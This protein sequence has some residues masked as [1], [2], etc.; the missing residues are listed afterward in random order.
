VGGSLAD[1]FDRRRLL[2][3]TQ[4]SLTAT[5]AGLMVNALSDRPAL[6]PIYLCTTAAAGLSGV[7]APT[8]AAA[9]PTLVGRR[10]VPSAAALNQTLIQLGAVAGPALAGLVIARFSLGAAYAID[11]V[12]FG[13][14]IAAL[15]LMEP[16]IPLGGGTKAGFGSIAEGL[17]YL[18][19]QRA[20]Q[21]TFLVDIVAMV[22]GMPRALFPQI[23]T[24]L[25]GGGAGTVGL[26]Y[27][28]PGVGAFAGAVTTGWVSGVL[29]PGRAVLIAVAVWGL[30]IAGFGMATWLPV[31]LLL[32]VVAGWADVL[33]AVFRGTILQLQVPDRLRGRL[34]AINI[35]VVTGGPRLGDAE[36]GAVAALT[37]AQASVVSGGLACLAGVAVLARVR[38]ELA[39]WRP[40]PHDPDEMSGDV[41]DADGARSSQ[42]Q[43]DP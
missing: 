13:A 25:Y 27:A 40:P 43:G 1:A 31:G 20:V 15:L 33:S 37:S 39:A 9:I 42:S 21:G 11:V 5:S 30:A 18:R 32:L 34:S 26:L 22:F 6:W 7:D 16:M 24:E 35:A 29:R 4:L 14:A 8:R 19:T 36:A 41:D 3:V 2:L 10:L 28:A 17:R 23:G 38:P 12:T